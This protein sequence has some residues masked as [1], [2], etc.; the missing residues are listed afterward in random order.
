MSTLAVGGGIFRQ[1][2]PSNLIIGGKF[3][4]RETGRTFMKNE[5]L[6]ATQAKVLILPRWLIDVSDEVSRLV[7]MGSD[8][9]PSALL[10]D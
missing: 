5:H 6:N 8:W 2:G 7:T 1:V 3:F 4:K 10:L 9:K